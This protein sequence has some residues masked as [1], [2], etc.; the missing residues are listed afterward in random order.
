V[1]NSITRLQLFLLLFYLSSCAVQQAPTKSPISLVANPV[2]RYVLEAPV[3][4]KARNSATTRLKS[5]TTWSLVG[6][7]EQGEV[8]QTKDQVVIVNSFN[9]HEAFIVIHENKVI[10]YY[11]PVEKTFVKSKPVNITLV[12]GSES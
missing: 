6:T 10:G 11:L 1:L 4:V 5:G 9:V 3:N 12:K 8:F 2:A 7:I